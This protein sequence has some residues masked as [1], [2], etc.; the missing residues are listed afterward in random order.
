MIVEHMRNCCSEMRFIKR[1]I[2]LS[3]KDV[4]C[5]GKDDEL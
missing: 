2:T 1:F 3:R 5:N 4:D